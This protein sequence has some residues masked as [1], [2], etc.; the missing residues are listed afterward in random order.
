MTT[1][2]INNLTKYVNTQNGE[3]PSAGVLSPNSNVGIDQTPGNRQLDNIELSGQSWPS[4]RERVSGNVRGSE[5][6]P[7]AVNPRTTPKNSQ[8]TDT[9]GPGSSGQRP[10]PHS[11]PSSSEIIKQ[12]RLV[13]G[14]SED[15]QEISFK[16]RTS[17]HWTCELCGS[18]V[19]I[20][21]HHKDFNKSNNA[22]SN[23]QALC[24]ECHLALHKRIRRQLK[25][26]AKMKAKWD[27][28]E[29]CE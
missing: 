6:M 22:E 24:N 12:K 19:N 27:K 2:N 18:K 16:F 15:W 1:C 9:E 5:P 25:H 29:R 3:L 20:V 11:S 21:V 4:S 10:G 28:R 13:A 17:K 23:L 7:A 8:H 14:Y 26:E